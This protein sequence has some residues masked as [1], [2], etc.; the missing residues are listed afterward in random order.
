[1]HNEAIDSEERKSIDQSSIENVSIHSR[2][3]KDLPILSTS[4]FDSEELVEY[5]FNEGQNP[6]APEDHA[7]HQQLP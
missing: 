7:N 6:A 3:S 2:S 5:I 4:T 1:V